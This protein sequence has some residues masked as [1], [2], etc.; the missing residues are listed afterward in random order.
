MQAQLEHSD[1]R[2]TLGIYTKTLAP[3]VLEMA[4]QVTNR[5]L[6]AADDAERDAIQ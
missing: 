1:I 5:L 4:N 6:D 3:E 2:S